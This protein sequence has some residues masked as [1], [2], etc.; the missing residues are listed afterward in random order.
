MKQIFLLLF[1]FLYTVNAQVTQEWVATYSGLQFPEPITSASYSQAVATDQQGNVYVTGYSLGAVNG[2]VYE[3]DIATVKYNSSGIEQ[4]VRRYGSSNSTEVAWAM[5]LDGEGNVYVTGYSYARI[6]STQNLLTLKYSSDGALL[7]DDKLSSNKPS[8]GFAITVGNDGSVY[9]AGYSTGGGTGLDYVTIKYSSS[10]TREWVRFYN[11]PGNLT[12][13]AWSI[14]TDNNGNVYV[15]GQSRGTSNGDFLTIK[16]NSAG[17]T[18]WEARY[19]GP[20][21]L[22]DGANSIAIDSAGNVYVTGFRLNNATTRLFVTV[23]YN[24]DGEL[25]WVR[26]YPIGSVN[27]T[28]NEGNSVKVDNAGNIYVTGTRGSNTIATLKY[29]PAGTLLWERLTNGRFTYTGGWPLDKMMAIDDESSIYITFKPTDNDADFRTIKYDTNGLEVWAETYNSNGERFA[30]TVDNQKNVYITGWEWSPTTLNYV[31][32]KYSQEKEK[33]YP[34]FIVP[35]IAGTYS[36]EIGSAGDLPWLLERGVHPILSQIDPL[37]NVYHDLIKTL[38]NVGYE[39]DKDLFVVNYDWRLIPGPVDNVFDG[40]ISG[41]SGASITDNNFSYAVDYL[42]W[43]IKKACERWGLEHNEELDSIDVITHSTGG[44]V[45]RSYIQSNAYGDIYDSMNNYRLPK[46][47]NFVMIGVPNRGASKAWNPSQDN[48]IADIAYIAVLSKIINRA[49]QKVIQGV[50]IPG[51]D[52]NITLG[53]ILN[54]NS[55]PD[56]VKFIKLYVPTIRYLLAT[57]DFFDSGSGYVNLNNDEEVRN[58]ILLDLNNGFDLIPDRNPNDFLDS[59]KVS[60]IYG[61]EKTTATWVQPRTDFELFAVLPFTAWKPQNVSSGTNWFKDISVPTGGDETVPTISSAGQFLND[62][63]AQLFPFSAVDH[64][65]IVSKA[66]VQA[67]IL[68]L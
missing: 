37:A 3:Y 23:K 5:A 17:V 44:L 18:Q 55:E 4:W 10:G 8:E 32:I 26:P 20:F 36:S 19:N 48:W 59:A 53:S 39:Q 21:N 6:D 15:T 35:G 65:S 27:N 63:R 47:R 64:T 43:Y 62:S 60:V 13:V 14:A 57:Y 56:P 68:N 7:W 2:N 38:E 41:L 51:P 29:N 58:S 52:Y 30:I 50:T 67:A 28:F 61:T 33:R 42:G 16:Y 66:E 11:G 45:T 54:S 31:T 49:Y 46:I 24:T 40:H 22:D 9:V 1:L 25:Q 12:D 34:V